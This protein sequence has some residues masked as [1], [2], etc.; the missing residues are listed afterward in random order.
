MAIWSTKLLQKKYLTKHESHVK[1]NDTIRLYLFQIVLPSTYSAKLDI[2]NMCVCMCK[3][4]LYILSNVFIYY[5][6]E[7]E[8]VNIQRHTRICVR[9][10]T[11]R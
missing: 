9:E 6:Y 10:V 1:N 8:F 7:S 5:L 2:I 4:G 11:T 3:I